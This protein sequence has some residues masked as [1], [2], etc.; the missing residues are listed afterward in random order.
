LIDRLNAANRIPDREQREKAIAAARAAAP[1]AP[2]RVFVGKMPDRSAT[3]SLAD[4]EGRPRLRMMVDAAG[5]SRIEILD[6]L[7][8]VTARIPADARAKP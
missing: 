6:S 8:A 1:P 7:G 4:G 3:V 5:D 2:R